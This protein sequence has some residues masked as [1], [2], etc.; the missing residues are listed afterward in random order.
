MNAFEFFLKK[1]SIEI[2]QKLPGFAA[3]KLMAP[4]GRKPTIEYLNQNISPKKSAVLI[5]IYPNE[6]TL[7]QK[8]VLIERAE[9]DGRTHSGQIALPGGKFDEVLD[10]NLTE[11]ALRETEEEIG[12]S[13]GLVSV[14]GAL[15]PLYIPV[16]N[17]M[18]HPFVGISEDGHKFIAQDAE[19]KN[20]IEIE[21]NDLF[22]EKNKNKAVK[23]IKVKNRDMEVPC[24]DVCGKMIWGATAMILS[25]LEE[26]V[27]RAK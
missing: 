17:Y 23:Y 2:N 3:Q 27:K 18:V 7:S 14:I 19:V 5:L 12:I 26:I 11:T 15:T 21:L 10:K 1:L 22:A 8:T 6:K 25:E 16:S 24:Y 20:I 13:R 4:L 9:S